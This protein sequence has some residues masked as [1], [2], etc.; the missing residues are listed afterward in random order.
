MRK[1]YG[2]KNWSKLWAKLEQDGN[3]GIDYCINPILYPKICDQ[4]NLTNNA[5]IV[6]FGAGTNILGI[7]FL[8]GYDEDIP[9]LKLC[10]KLEHARENVNKFIGVE[11]S[12]NL[13]NE[14]KKYHRDLGFSDKIDIEK[15][16]LVENNNLPFKNHSIDLAISRNFLMHLSINDLIFHF[17]EVTRILK[18]NGRYIIAILNPSY[19]LKKYQENNKNKELING[20]RYSFSHGLKGEN[21]I[22]YHHFKTIEQYEEVFRKNFKIIDKKICLPITNEFKNTHKRYYWKD[23]PMSFV[24]EL[25]KI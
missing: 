10:T 13:V 25:V 17:A 14:A 23:C 21:G 6:D 5:R 20:E 22:F 9:A 4:L 24:Y 2:G 11:Q 15:I 19:E 18:N 12:L 3:I 16:L 7:Q 8:F 1:I